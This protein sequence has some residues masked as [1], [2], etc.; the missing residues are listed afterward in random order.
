M[1]VVFDG[2]NMLMEGG[3]IIGITITICGLISGGFAA[4]PKSRFS[5]YARYRF[6]NST[7]YAADSR[8]V[9]AARASRNVSADAGVY[10]HLRDLFRQV[11]PDDTVRPYRRSLE[12]IVSEFRKSE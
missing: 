8:F 10:G 2:M 3:L 11:Q 5:L 9:F 6:V 7:A 12:R 1:C 4:L